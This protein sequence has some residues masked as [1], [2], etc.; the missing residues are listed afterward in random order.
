MYKWVFSQHFCNIY[1]IHVIQLEHQNIYTNLREFFEV[2]YEYFLIAIFSFH[3]ILVVMKTQLLSSPYCSLYS[4]TSPSR[5][6]LP[7]SLHLLPFIPPSPIVSWYLHSS[8]L[9]LSSLHPF[10]PHPIIPQFFALPR[11]TFHPP[12]PSSLLPLHPCLLLHL[13]HLRAEASTEA[14]PACN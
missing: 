3:T 14:P 2:S 8:S 13:V 1:N 11:F 12:D 6:F 5:S 7:I 9:R 10:T 4:F